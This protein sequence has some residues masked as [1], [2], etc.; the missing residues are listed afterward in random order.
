[1]APRSPARSDALIST[2]NTDAAIA[3]AFVHSASGS[4]EVSRRSGLAVT[5]ETYSDPMRHRSFGEQF[6]GCCH[7]NDGASIRWVRWRMTISFARHQ[8]PPAIIRHAV[9]LYLLTVP[10]MQGLL[11]QF[12]QRSAAAIYSVFGATSLPTLMRYADCG[13]QLSW[14]ALEPDR[15]SGISQFRSDRFAIMRPFALAQPKPIDAELSGG[16]SIGLL[17]R[18]DRPCD[19]SCLVGQGDG[20]DV[21]MPPA[22]KPGEPSVFHLTAPHTSHSRPS[23]MNE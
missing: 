14:R 9:W 15:A 20:G 8:F 4:P 7:G 11:R 12:G 13:A 18:H 3:M 19:S 21:E 5:E 10:A 2:P 22:Q 23:A 1:L 17:C 16:P 6:A